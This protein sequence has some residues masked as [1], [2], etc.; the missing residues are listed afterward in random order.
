MKEVFEEHKEEYLVPV[1][2]DLL[3]EFEIE[4]KLGRNSQKGYL[5]LCYHM[6]I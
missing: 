1:V 6:Y 5:R 3:K 2:H 4:N